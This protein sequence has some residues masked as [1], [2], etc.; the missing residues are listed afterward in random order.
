LNYLDK[1]WQAVINLISRGGIIYQNLVSCT[2]Y[3]FGFSGSGLIFYFHPSLAKDFI[4]HLLVLDPRQRY[5][6]RAALQHPFITQNCANDIR[7]LA[8]CP[9]RVPPQ[10]FELPTS[11]RQSSAAIPSISLALPPLAYQNLA[12]AVSSRNSVSNQSTV[13]ASSSSRSS[14]S[15]NSAHVNIIFLLSQLPLHLSNY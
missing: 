13:R 8:A 11:S 6:A 12:H 15:R 2:F 14:Q 4:R 1:L 10:P 9:S 3:I 7:G 5:T